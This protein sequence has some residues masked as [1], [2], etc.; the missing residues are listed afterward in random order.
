[1]MTVIDMPLL[2]PDVLSDTA[3]GGAVGCSVKNVMGL[4]VVGIVVGPIV[5]CI[6]GVRD[7]ANVVGA[8]EGRMDGAFVGVPVAMQLYA[9]Q[10]VESQS[11]GRP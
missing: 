3:L 4:S 2:D 7:G 9:L 8:D 6:D 5:G 10:R 11:L 1:M